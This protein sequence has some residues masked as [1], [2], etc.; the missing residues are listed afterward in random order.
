ME[1]EL[2]AVLWNICETC[3]VVISTFTVKDLLM[4]GNAFPRLYWGVEE[5][6]PEN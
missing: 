4:R 6:S 3:E 2:R 5:L 1:S